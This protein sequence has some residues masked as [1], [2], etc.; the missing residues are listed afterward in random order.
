MEILDVVSTPA[1]VP[2][3]FV[4]QGSSWHVIVEPTRWFERVAWWETAQRMQR[5]RGVS[6]IGTVSGGSRSGR[7][8]F[9]GDRL[10]K[11]IGCV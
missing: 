6:N 1:G 4:T 11:A 2:V 8:C 5:G 3:S 7:G 9:I 10:W